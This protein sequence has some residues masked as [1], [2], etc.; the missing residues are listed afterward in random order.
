MK[1]A[2]LISG[3][4]RDAKNCYDSVKT[5]ILDKFNPDVFINTW[6]PSNQIKDHRDKYLPNEMN[7]DEIIEKYNPKT[8]E[9]EDFD[10][11]HMK[12]VVDSLIDDIKAKRLN[13]YD[14]TLPWETRFENVFYMHYKIWKTKN[15]KMIYEQTNGIVYDRVIKSRFDLKFNEF[16]DIVPEKNTVYVP[17]GWDC[18]GGLSDLLA[19]ADSETMNKY[20]NLFTYLKPYHDNNIPLHPESALRKHMEIMDI[21]VERFRLN[22]FLRGVYL[23]E[24]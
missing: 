18:R 4:I 5:H 15:L 3:Q 12:V 14:G 1:T 19:I 21:R 2:L 6:K 24:P 16:P 13:A 8:I 22:Y 7:I 11:P 20:C 10:N 17:S 9:V 23:G